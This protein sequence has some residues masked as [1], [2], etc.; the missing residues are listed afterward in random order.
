MGR[1]GTFASPLPSADRGVVDVHEHEQRVER[2]TIAAVASAAGVGVGT[3]SRV[4]N[5]SPAVR[6]ATRARVRAAIAELGYRPSRLAAGLSR[7]STRTIAILVPF[8][9][10]PSVVARLAGAIAELEAAGYDTVVCN[11]ENAR[12]RDHHL[13]ALAERH[14]ADGILCVSLALPR[15]HLERLGRAEVPVVTIDTRAPGIPSTE[16]DDV[17]GGALATNHLLQLGHRRIG[18]IGD[19][20]RS[21]LGFTSTGRRL[22]GYRMALAAQG[23][24]PDPE[25]VGLGPHGTAAAEHQASQ[26]LGQPTPP[27]AIFAA[28]DTQALGVLAA[29]ERAQRAVPEELSV[30]GYDDIEAAAQ[31]RLTTVRQPLYDSGASGA[32][33]L[34]ATLHKQPVRPLREVLPL[35]L[36][37][38]W[39]SGPAPSSAGSALAPGPGRPRSVLARAPLR[40]GA[41]PAREPALS[42]IGPGEVSRRFTPY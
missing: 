10:R 31:L 28:S 40:T 16:V 12:Q 20:R 3:V 26:L 1:G 4:L 9:T 14:R 30:V 42:G 19:D 38:R 33:R 32:K 21:Q 37:R 24:T 29:A 36:V 11:V 34:V 5:D 7:G 25:L 15:V 35:E 27:T 22:R 8:L 39:S 2:A 17:A 13:A 41:V 6:P 18:F 23:I